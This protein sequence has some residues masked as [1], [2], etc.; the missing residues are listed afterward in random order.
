MTDIKQADAMM[1]MAL[2]DMTALRG[3]GD[4]AIFASV[5][6]KAVRFAACPI[7]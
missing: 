5:M 7:P 4:A 3:M 2:R 6:P 1:R